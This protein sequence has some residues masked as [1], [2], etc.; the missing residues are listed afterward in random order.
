MHCYC[1]K[2][3]TLWFY[4]AAMHPKEAD[5]FANSTDADQT[6]PFGAV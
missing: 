4:N 6:A 1:P 2:E 5:G 3:R